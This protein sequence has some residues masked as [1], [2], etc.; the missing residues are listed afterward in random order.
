MSSSCCSARQSFF[1]LPLPCAIRFNLK[2]AAGRG[3]VCNDPGARQGAMRPQGCSLQRRATPHSRQERHMIH[4]I[5][6]L[7]F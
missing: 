7:P 3:G 1:A 6:A 2:T 5:A 4:L